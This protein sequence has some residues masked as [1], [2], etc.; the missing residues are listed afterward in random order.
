M[1]QPC[2]A[3]QRRRSR[4][5]LTHLSSIRLKTMTIETQDD[6]EGLQLHNAMQKVITRGNPIIVTRH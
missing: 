5:K 3:C 1:S 4:C 2:V 6:L